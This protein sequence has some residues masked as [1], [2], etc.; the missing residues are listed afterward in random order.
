[1]SKETDLA[2][3][4][5]EAT[6][7][8]RRTKARDRLDALTGAVGGDPND[9]QSWFEQV[10]ALAGDDAA[11]VPWADLKPKQAL[12]DWLADN[13]GEGRT[14]LDIACGLGDNAEALATHG[15]Q[16]TAFDFAEG[17]VT[18]AQ[19]RF[20]ETSVTYKPADLLSPPETWL[21]AFDLVHECYTLQALQGDMRERAFGATAALVK[22]G[23]DLLVITRTRLTEEQPDG[24]PWPL[25][26]S[27]LTRFEALGFTLINRH[28]YTLTKQTRAIPHT[29]LH[30]RRQGEG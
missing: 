29:R 18:W 6:F 11:G 30:L 28:D 26:P 2:D 24:P 7:E 21:G 27:E 5:G 19:K 22:P 4:P 10:Y 1:M 12:L 13:S 17:A 8:A 3:L 16:T 25:S 15:W 23:G 14:A 9:R 20:P